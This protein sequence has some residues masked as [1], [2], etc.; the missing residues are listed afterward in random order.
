MARVDGTAPGHWS[1]VTDN[2][3]TRCVDVD[4]EGAIADAAQCNDYAEHMTAEERSL[5]ALPVAQLWYTAVADGRAM[6]YVRSERP[7]VLAHIPIGDAYQAPG[8]HIRGLRLAD[9]RAF[10][11]A[12]ARIARIFGGN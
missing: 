9:I 2:H 3:E 8:A 4:A 11:D 5:E 7:L 10:R 6:Y 1:R 12:N